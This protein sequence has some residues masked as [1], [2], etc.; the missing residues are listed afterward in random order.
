MFDD[1]FDSRGGVVHDACTEPLVCLGVLG[2]ISSPL[3]LLELSSSIEKRKDFLTCLCPSYFVCFLMICHCFYILLKN[4]KLTRQLFQKF[5]LNVKKNLMEYCTYNSC[6]NK[7]TCLFLEVTI[8]Y[9]CT[10][11]VS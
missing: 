8:F 2:I 6:D 1:R 4:M 3:S 7:L 10:G 9:M 5:F 11:E